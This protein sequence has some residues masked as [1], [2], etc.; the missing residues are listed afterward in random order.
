MKR[1][2]SDSEVKRL[3]KQAVNPAIEEIESEISAISSAG[4]KR[5]IVETLPTGSAIKTNVIYMVLDPNA[6]TG[7]VYNEYM[8]INSNWEL[9]GTTEVSGT[10][11]V[12]NPTIP[13]GATVTELDALKIATDYFKI[14]KP[15][16]FI[17][18]SSTTLTEALR[19]EILSDDYFV[20]VE[21]DSNYYYERVNAGTSKYFETL[22]NT[23]IYGNSNY[24]NKL[25][26]QFRN[27]T[28]YNYSTSFGT[29]NNNYYLPIS[30]IN[31]SSKNIPAK[32]INSKTDASTNAPSGTV[33]TADGNGNASWET[34]PASGM[35]NPMTT[36]GDVIV[37]GSSGTPT[38]L[39]KGTDGQ[40]LKMVSGAP[41]WA[42]DA[43]G[44]TNFY[45]HTIAVNGT[46]IT[47]KMI[48][49]LQTP[50]LD[51]SDFLAVYNAS[52][53]FDGNFDYSGEVYSSILSLYNTE[54][55]A[56]MYHL[57]IQGDIVSYTLPLT[58]TF[59]DSVVQWPL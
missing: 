3:A 47:F 45:E 31:D 29:A 16:H 59:T 58:A 7:N 48:S 39:A 1:M 36:A 2:H 17:K 53:L 43:S 42:N 5:E 38:R 13:S 54:N 44:G 41:A 37:G 49:L 19:N 52:L 27:A 12:G 14:D 22:V 8:Y 23:S 55:G 34:P 33:L 20:V 40:V 25:V 4:L 18:L 21:S 26:I 32:I 51:I 28:V 9:I 15:I 11:V 6:S 24:N 56:L 46:T 57:D 50:V 10:E 35:T 30:D